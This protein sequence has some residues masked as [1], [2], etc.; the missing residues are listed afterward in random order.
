MKSWASISVGCMPSSRT[1]VSMMTVSTSSGRGQR[2][3]W[4][5][6]LAASGIEVEASLLDLN[7]TISDLLFNTAAAYWSA[8]AA[9]RSLEVYR[10][11]EAR[12]A[13][14]ILY[15]CPAADVSGDGC[16][17]ACTSLYKNSASPICSAVR[18]RS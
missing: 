11:A 3:R 7:Q 17:A 18:S 10:E 12:G 14:E 15:S 13:G 16:F 8:I 1:N 4:E 2:M 9:R 6:R 5:K